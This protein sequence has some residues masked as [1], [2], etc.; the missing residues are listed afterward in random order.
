MTELDGDSIFLFF[1]LTESARALHAI[2][3]VDL[4]AAVRVQIQPGVERREMQS[5]FATFDWPSSSPRTFR[6]FFGRIR[7][8]PLEV[9]D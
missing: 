1:A 8:Q 7:T 5:V 2:E 3:Q 4:L 6:R 9:G